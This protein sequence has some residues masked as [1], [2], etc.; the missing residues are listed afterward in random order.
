VNVASAREAFAAAL[1]QLRLTASQLPRPV[2]FMEVCGTHT[3]NAGRCGL[4]GLLPANV[5]LRSGPGCPVCVTPSS[6]I[7]RMVHLAS[8]PGVTLCTY[9]DMLRVPGDGISLEQARGRGAEVRIVYSP[10]EAVAWAER[11]PDR[12]VVLAAVGFETTAP[13]TA[14]TMLRA[15]RRGVMNFSVLASHK[16]IVPAMGA[17]L[18]QKD[19]ALAGFLCPGHVS[20]IIGAEAYRP[21]VD[22]W[23]IPC[24]VAGF[25]PPH[26]MR[27]LARLVELA[28]DGEAALVNAYAEAVADRGNPAALAALEM[29]FEPIDVPWR[30]LGKISRSGL[31]IRSR[32]AA[33]D[34]RRRFDL[35]AFA[36]REPVGCICGDVLAG[37]RTPRD[38]ALFDRLC[39]PLNP[40]GP[41]MVSSEGTCHAWHRYAD[42]RERG[43][44]IPA[45][46][47]PVPNS[48]LGMTNRAEVDL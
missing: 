17:L 28:R 27:A 47:A 9:G 18:G 20:V 40:V 26:M 14:A 38:C 13:A 48:T 32:F 4:P 29:V 46:D 25:E 11:E 10:L 23:R 31:R 36:D 15:E 16:R 22:R 42:A 41:C 19:V 7:D 44:A 6:E 39:T 12:Q 33:W 8:L 5:A 2:V 35:P 30:G 3:M 37:R 24:V 21:L 1:R 43:R 45:T 34:A